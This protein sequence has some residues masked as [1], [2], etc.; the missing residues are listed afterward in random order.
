LPG[1]GWSDHRSFW[2]AGWKALMVTDT[3]VFR[4][5]HYHQRTDLPR[6]VDF[7]RLARVVEG[8]EHV[9]QRLATEKQP[10]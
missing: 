7:A 4:D 3:A 1:I 2:L 9:V 8:L 10:R 5:D 6:N